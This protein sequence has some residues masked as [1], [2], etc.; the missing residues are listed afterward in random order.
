MAL[1]FTNSANDQLL[2]PN[3]PLDGD[4]WSISLWF[5]GRGNPFG[6]GDEFYC[7]NCNQLVFQTSTK[8]QSFSFGGWTDRGFWYHLTISLDNRNKIWK[9]FLNDAEERDWYQRNINWDYIQVRG[10]W[11]PPGR[12]ET[13][14]M[15]WYL[16][17][18][19]NVTCFCYDWNWGSTYLVYPEHGNR[20]YNR[21]NTQWYGT[22][23]WIAVREGID[24]GRY[25]HTLFLA[26]KKKNGGDDEKAWQSVRQALA[27]VSDLDWSLIGKCYTVYDG[28]DSMRRHIAAQIMK[29]SQ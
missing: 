11:A 17:Y 9:A 19:N 8:K 5:N 1:A 18:L 3:V 16:R 28:F 25:I 6:R 26:M 29:N 23:G 12:Y 2:T 4:G 13:G 24:N 15:A 20:G 10:R 27:P 22:L 21:P 7:Q 14:Y